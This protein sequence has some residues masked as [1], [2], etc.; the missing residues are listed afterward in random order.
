[1]QK[2]RGMPKTTTRATIVIEAAQ[3]DRWNN[4]FR[5]NIDHWGGDKTFVANIDETDGARRK[6]THAIASVA[7]TPGQWKLVREFESKIAGDYVKDRFEEKP[8][9]ILERKKLERKRETKR[10]RA[11]NGRGRG[12]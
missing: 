12:V 10:V 3:I 11:G 4:F 2:R 1:M 7:L 9:Q 8:E 6:N 5:D